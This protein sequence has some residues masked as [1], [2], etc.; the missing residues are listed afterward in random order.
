M[1][2]DYTNTKCAY[3]MILTKRI[4][5]LVDYVKWHVIINKVFGG[6]LCHWPTLNKSENW[7][8]YR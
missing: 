3:D 1:A 8:V 7:M 4:K 6:M 5:K 2:C